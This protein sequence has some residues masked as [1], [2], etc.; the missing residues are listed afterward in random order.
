MG[1]VIQE[2]AEEAAAVEVASE[3][4]AAVAAVAVEPSSSGTSS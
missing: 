3:S 4:V 1:V 2:V